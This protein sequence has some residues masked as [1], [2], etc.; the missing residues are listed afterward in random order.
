MP[1]RIESKVQDRRGRF[2]SASDY[3]DVPPVLGVEN[4]IFPVHSCVKGRALRRLFPIGAMLSH[5]PFDAVSRSYRLGGHVG[6][7]RDDG[8]PI[9]SHL[10]VG[11]TN[12]PCPRRAEFVEYQLF[13]GLTPELKVKVRKF[14][15][16]VDRFENQ[17]KAAATARAKFG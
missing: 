11:P 13:C 2:A 17:A 5:R 8:W 7:L 10:R 4:V 16:S 1:R 9:I 6:A 12:D 14:C 15:E 3:D